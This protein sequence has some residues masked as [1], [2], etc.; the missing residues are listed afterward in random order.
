[1][2]EAFGVSGLT[3]V[4][5]FVNS[6]IASPMLCLKALMVLDIAAFA[7]YEFSGNDFVFMCIN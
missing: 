6:S 5:R 7:K 3:Q 4:L 2:L 1:M